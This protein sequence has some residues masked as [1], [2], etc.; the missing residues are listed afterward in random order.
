MGPST[1]IC[2][3]QHWRPCLFRHLHVFHP[4]SRTDVKTAQICDSVSTPSIPTPPPVPPPGRYPPPVI[5]GCRARNLRSCDANFL[6][7]IPKPVFRH[8]TRGLSRTT[9]PF[10]PMLWLCHPGPNDPRTPNPDSV[11][12]SYTLI[13][14]G[15][16]DRLSF[17]RHGR[18]SWD[19]LHMLNTLLRGRDYPSQPPTLRQ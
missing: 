19:L 17:S 16:S 13:L 15:R 9:F 11:A 18:S 1:D 12:K 4:L 2:G 5:W 8:P 14:G 7:G 6:F 3:V 10:T